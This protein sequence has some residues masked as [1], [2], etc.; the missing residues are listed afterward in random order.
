MKWKRIKSHNLPNLHVL[1]N[2]RGNECA[3]IYKLKDTK[4]DK[5]AWCMFLDIGENGK[6]IG[7]SWSKEEA[8]QIVES[9]V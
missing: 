6:F 9:R 2:D 4:T 3:F 5:N 7:H 8:K 1:L